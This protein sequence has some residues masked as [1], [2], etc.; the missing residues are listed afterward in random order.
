MLIEL[1]ANLRGILG[2][3]KSGIGNG[4]REPKQSERQQGH[5]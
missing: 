4:R 3:L 5:Q 2:D 1:H